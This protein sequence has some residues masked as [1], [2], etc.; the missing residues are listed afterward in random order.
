MSFNTLKKLG[1]APTNVKIKHRTQ[2]V[3]TQNA[4]NQNYEVL[5]N[6]VG[7][8]WSHAAGTALNTENNHETNIKQITETKDPSQNALFLYSAPTQL[9]YSGRQYLSSSWPEVNGTNVYPQHAYGL[10]ASQPNLHANLHANAYDHAGGHESVEYA[11]IDVSEVHNRAYTLASNKLKASIHRNF[12][13]AAQNARTAPEM[14]HTLPE[15]SQ[16]PVSPYYEPVK[17][18]LSRGSQT[19]DANLNNQRFAYNTLA[20]MGLAYARSFDPNNRGHKRAYSHEFDAHF[21]HIHEPPVR[22]RRLTD[23]SADDPQWEAYKPVSNPH[24]EIDQSE[25]LSSPTFSSSSSASIPTFSSSR[26]ARYT[27]EENLFIHHARHKSLQIPW[28]IIPDVEAVF[29]NLKQQRSPLSMQVHFSQNVKPRIKALQDLDQTSAQKF[30][31]IFNRHLDR[32]QSS[33]VEQFKVNG[34]KETSKNLAQAYLRFSMNA[35]RRRMKQ[36]LIAAK[37]KKDEATYRKRKMK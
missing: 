32:V 26:H 23:S 34:D 15:T 19:M 37:K 28:N 11:P 21:A 24:Y 27:A 5:P 4:Q 8:K 20:P 22:K 31:N 1:S 36:A 10:H 33:L 12:P 2:P 3:G 29:Y 30:K 13:P 25:P 9:P 16:F 17:P 14:R 7:R 18:K 35:S 6:F